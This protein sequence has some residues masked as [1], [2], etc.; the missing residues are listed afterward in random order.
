M[1]VISLLSGERDCP[2][3]SSSS[4]NEVSNGSTE[5]LNIGGAGAGPVKKVRVC[6]S[7]IEG[8]DGESDESDL[9]NT[10]TSQVD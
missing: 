8:S 9:E 4:G 3:V 7:F 10:A 1:E 5:E 2:F 6:S